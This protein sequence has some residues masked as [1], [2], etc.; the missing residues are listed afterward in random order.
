MIAL[1]LLSPLLMMFIYTTLE[2][3]I[4]DMEECGHRAHTALKVM[5][6]RKN[7]KLTSAT[8]KDFSTGEINHIVMNESNRIWSLIELGPAYLNTAFNLITASVVAF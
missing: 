2:Y 8:N 4:F 3:F 1:A 7:F 6:F 5:L